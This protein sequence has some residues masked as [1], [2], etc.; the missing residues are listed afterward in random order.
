MYSRIE[1]ITPEWAKKALEKN[2]LN[3]RIRKDAVRYYARD[4]KEGKWQ[5]TPQGI[6]FYE[7]GELADGQHRLYAVILADTP[8]EMY[9]T[10]DVPRACTIQ[11][12]CMTRKQADSLVL[13]G[14]SPTVANNFGVALVNMLFR[15]VIS[16]RPTIQTI[17]SFV[18]ENE[19]EIETAL[20][21]TSSGST[22]P[23]SR[24][25][26]CQ[27]AAFCC[28]VCGVPKQTLERFFSVFN[29]GFYD[30]IE[31][32]SAIVL[33]NFATNEYV[34]NNVGDRKELMSMTLLAIQDFAAKRPRTRRYTTKGSIPYIG[35]VQSKLMQKYIDTY[36]M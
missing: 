28:V 27:A 34:G 23:F 22:N 24:K 7:D 12:R 4:I 5:L 19:R 16:M 1:T 29:T 31:E 15:Y 11:D 13:M 10:Y 9:V 17:N 36:K 32:T 18:C 33:R 6:S 14:V 26:P 2:K 21:V 8:V 25:G 3:R 35:Y 20:S 30:G